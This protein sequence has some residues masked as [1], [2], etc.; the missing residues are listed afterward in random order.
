MSADL[1]VRSECGV[2]KHDPGALRSEHPG[3][4][5]VGEEEQER[6]VTSR[7]TPSRFQRTNFDQQPPATLCYQRWREYVQAT[8]T[9]ACSHAHSRTRNGHYRAIAG[10]GVPTAKSLSF[11]WYVPHPGSLHFCSVCEA[12]RS[13][14]AKSGPSRPF[15]HYSCRRA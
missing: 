6:K 8:K 14:Q 15:I 3:D 13:P 1:D 10:A 7:H 4:E 12:P 2:Q 5:R 9:D 11:S